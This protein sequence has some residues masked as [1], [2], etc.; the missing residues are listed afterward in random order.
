MHGEGEQDTSRIHRGSTILK[1]RIQVVQDGEVRPVT[2]HDPLSTSGDTRLSGFLLEQHSVPAGELGATFVNHLVGVNI[3]TAYRQEWRT[4]GRRGSV[5]IPPGGVCLCSQQEIW[6]RWDRP[7]TFLALSIEPDVLQS[8]AYESVNQK[9]ELRGEPSILDPIVEASLTALQFE[10]Q[11]GCPTGPLLAESIATDLSA[12]LLRQYATRPFNF[13]GYKGG[14]PRPR[15]HRVID[16]IEASLVREL[17]IGE[18]AG[19]AEMS[20]YHFGKLFKESTGW[21]V[22]QYVMKRRLQ[23]AMHLLSARTLAISETGAAVGL[24]NQS[25][26]T[27]F[28]RQHTGITPRRYQQFV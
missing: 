3:G 16:Y 1:R 11:S 10:V 19:V 23:R 7:R 17:R 4:D 5:L 26:F 14:I 18:L 27:K 12:F 22:H 24:P 9:V 8:V 21:T 25:Q 13:R 6:C 2:T 15:L 20:P 28:F